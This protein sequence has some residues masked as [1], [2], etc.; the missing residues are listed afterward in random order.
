MR[1]A[2]LQ[3]WYAPTQWGINSDGLFEPLPQELY[4]PITYP[5]APAKTA[6]KELAAYEDRNLGSSR[7]A[8]KIGTQFTFLA[9]DN[10]CWVQCED[11]NS[12]Q[13]SS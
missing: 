8:V 6:L 3:T 9:T 2:V 10:I 13:A 7:S 1:L 11:E 12:V 4:Y 5:G